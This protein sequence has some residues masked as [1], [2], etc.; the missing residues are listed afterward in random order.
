MSIPSEL[1]LK[2]RVA[3]L[4]GLTESL[5]DEAKLRDWE[6]IGV[7][8]D[9]RGRPDALRTVF[10]E[11]PQGEAVCD[12]LIEVL[13]ASRPDDDDGQTVA[14][15]VVPQTEEG[16]R[17]LR[18]KTIAW[19][20]SARQMA[21]AA[22]DEELRD[23]L[24]GPETIYVLWGEAPPLTANYY[25]TLDFRMYELHETFGNTLSSRCP[26]YSWL[27]GACYSIACDDLLAD[28]V[29]WPWLADSSALDDPYRPYFE[30]WRTG[31]EMRFPDR[32]DLRL[33]VEDS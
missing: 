16:E 31:A 11:L 4:V 29:R 28:F 18:Q 2:R 25:D 14:A 6:M 15:D 9:F 13:D 32:D 8:Q 19:L 30:F 22:G 33:Y 23:E 17:A 7:F 27:R 12:R 1:D 10:A 3:D 21:H 20:H 24:I 5:N 26:A